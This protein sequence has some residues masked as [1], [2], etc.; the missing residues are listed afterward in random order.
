[1]LLN[2]MMLRI[3]GGFV[4]YWS[5]YSCPSFLTIVETAALYMDLF[6]QTN[7]TAVLHAV[8]HLFPIYRN[9]IL[10]C[11]IDFKHK[12]IKI[13]QPMGGKKTC[14]RYFWYYGTWCISE[15]CNGFAVVTLTFLV[16]IFFS[17]RVGIKYLFTDDK[18]A[19]S[20]Q[21]SVTL[22]RPS[23]YT[24]SHVHF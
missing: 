14:L 19:I 15:R 1:M 5:V 22:S 11:W 8:P 18:P 24:D 16:S 10:W 7:I 6:I 23:S 20:A 2:K 17:Q 3:L 4:K 21:P 9:Q 13:K 12:E